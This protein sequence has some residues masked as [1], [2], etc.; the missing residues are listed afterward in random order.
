MHMGP[1]PPPEMLDGY[2]RTLPGTAERILSMAEKQQDHRQMIEKAVIVGNLR[3]QRLGV[4]FAFLLGLTGIVCGTMGDANNARSGKQPKRVRKID[5]S[6]C[7]ARPSFASASSTMS[8]AA[9]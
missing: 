9:A 7:S 5:Q 6:Y 1:L 4:V 3:D 8:R 2:E